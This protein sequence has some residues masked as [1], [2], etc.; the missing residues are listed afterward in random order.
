MRLER[1]SLYH[2]FKTNCIAFSI[3]QALYFILTSKTALNCYINAKKNMRN[4]KDNIN[5]HAIYFVLI[6]LRNSF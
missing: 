1:A 5:K 2:A 3:K 4:I 6:I